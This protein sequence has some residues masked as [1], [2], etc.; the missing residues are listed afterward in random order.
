[1]FNQHAKWLKVTLGL[2]WRRKIASLN[3][4]LASHVWRQDHNGF[5]PS[6]PRV[7]RSRGEQEGGD[8]ARLSAAGRELSA[9]G[10]GSLSAEPALREYRGGGQASG[11]A[12]ADDGSGGAALH[13]G[14]RIWEWASNDRGADPDVVMGCA[15]M[16]RRW[17]YWRP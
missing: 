7:H 5:T 1:M 8:R 3:Y 15:G 12:V 2:P 16:C 13:G 17:K 14:D 9:V 4:L 10:D 6:G 11:A